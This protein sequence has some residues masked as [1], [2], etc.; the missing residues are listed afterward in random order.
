VEGKKTR[1]QSENCGAKNRSQKERS[2]VD[3]ELREAAHCK[4]QIKTRP[5]FF[6]TVAM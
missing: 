5:T 6:V 1:Q 4:T 3:L 2:V